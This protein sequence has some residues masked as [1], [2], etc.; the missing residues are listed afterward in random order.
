MDLLEGIH[1]SS[2]SE[3]QKVGGVGA[4]NIYEG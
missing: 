1:T 2:Y 4:V 3:Y